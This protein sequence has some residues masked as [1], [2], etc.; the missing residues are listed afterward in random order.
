[1]PIQ[2]TY[3]GVY[4]QEIPGGQPAVAGVSTASTAFVDFF[5][6][7]P[8]GQ[9]TRVASTQEFDR[10]FGGLHKL[11]E[12]SYGIYQYF[13]N[14]GQEAWIVRTGDGTATKAAIK[15]KIRTPGLPARVQASLDDFMAAQQAAKDAQAAAAAAQTALNDLNTATT[16]QQTEQGT[17]TLQDQAT[18]A[19]AATEQAANLTRQAADQAAAASQELAVA[20]AQSEAA[21]GPTAARTAQAAQKSANA[22]NQSSEAAGATNNIASAAQTA[23]TLADQA[24][25]AGQS[26][27]T[28]SSMAT[29]LQNA[30]TALDTVTAAQKAAAAANSLVQQA[31]VKD[32][33]DESTVPVPPD[34]QQSMATASAQAILAAAQTQAA[35]ESVVNAVQK[36][37]AADAKDL[38][39]QADGVLQNALKAV[40]A[41]S[42]ADWSVQIALT[43]KDAKAAS[44]AAQAAADQ[45]AGV[46]GIT[47][48]PAAGGGT[49]PAPAGGGTTPAP[50]P[51][52]GGTTPAPAPADG[53]TT[54]APAGGGATAGATVT[55][56][57]NTL[58]STVLTNASTAATTASGL[59]GT[60]ANEP[61]TS[62]GVTK[63]TVDAINRAITAANAAALQAKGAANDATVAANSVSSGDPT[64][65]ARSATS[66]AGLASQNTDAAIV[67]AKAV[68]LQIA[69]ANQTAMTSVQPAK[70][71]IAAAG[72]N[73]TGKDG[74]TTALKTS[75]AAL[76]CANN[77]A[78]VAQL[79]GSAA[80]QTS[81]VSV[82]AAG[83]ADAA[84]QAAEAAVLANQEA[85]LDPILTIE[86]INEGE[87]GNNLKI[88]LDGS[89]TIFSLRVTE[90]VTQNGVTRDVANESYPT[91]TIDES[92]T[93]APQALAKVNNDSKLVRLSQKGPKIQ[94]AYPDNTG[95]VLSGGINGGL[96]SPSQILDAMNTLDTIEPAIF[97]ILCIPAVG[98]MDD[99]HAFA[100]IP[101]AQDYCKKK[102][103]FFIADIPASVDSVAKMLTWQARYGNAQAYAMATYFPRLIIPDQLNDYRPRNV[104]ASGT[105]AGI[106][107]RTD[108]SRGVW[109]APAGIDAVLQGAEVAVKLNDDLNGQLN[110]LGVNVL[111]SFP[112]YGNIAWGARTLAGADPLSSEYKYINVRRL[113]NYIEESIYQSLKWAV[114]EPNNETL[115]T[116]IRLQINGFLSGLYGD[117]AFQGAT[118]AASYFVQC[119]GKTTTPLDIDLGVVNVLVG[120]A[121]VK[122]AEFVVLSFQQI[123]GQASA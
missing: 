102:R 97:N 59:V 62:S 85:N 117:G 54:P 26:A 103:A 104:A 123:A 23:A 22:A 51:A 12:A 11:S 61:G 18:A 66:A 24:L 8:M 21:S 92:V 108:T 65:A 47:S 118:P 91:L 109:K 28:A 52:D 43:L 14:G 112:I 86:A 94:G 7:G 99:S 20:I 58:L 107:A 3:P 13:L 42:D 81:A 71:A 27:S 6:R 39:A 121:P 4:V 72:K 88:S 113:M 56:L 67:Q 31:K 83:S 9:P 78:A 70:D 89:G 120:V 75:Q 116:K 49:T 98:N 41:A 106:Y 114:F 25:K 122:P 34:V 16:A 5:A 48:A 29:D 77:V 82:Q 2:V 33:E 90:S 110:P 30:L 37:P 119:D 95:S 40:Q 45:A 80:V 55:S 76:N 105:M 68:R 93:T 1:M 32:G 96:A 111:R 19:A 74:V 44:A 87:W 17:Q 69:Q 84:A 115:W 57:V 46:A 10:Q 79:V 35:A 50:A 53:G 101:S 100:V 64:F 60:V 63:A 15:I 36:L 73:P 38:P